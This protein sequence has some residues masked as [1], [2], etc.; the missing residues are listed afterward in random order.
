M[1]HPLFHISSL[2]IVSTIFSYYLNF[3]RSTDQSSWINCGSMNSSKNGTRIDW[4][5]NV[6]FKL[7]IGKSR[8]KMRL[9]SKNIRSLI[10]INRKNCIL[11]TDR[12]DT[13]ATA[14]IY[15]NCSLGNFDF[16]CHF[17]R[18]SKDGSGAR[19]TSSSSI[20]RE[21]VKR[22]ANHSK[23]NAWRS[24]SKAIENPL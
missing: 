5:P 4:L 18:N 6:F 17:R 2:T 21:A 20:A 9:K 13:F 23:R 11:L 10:F 24:V 22:S 15:S 19:P 3:N 12:V 7:S 1:N 14:N 16:Q 8:L